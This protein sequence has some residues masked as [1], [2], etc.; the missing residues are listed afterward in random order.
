MKSGTDTSSMSDE[1]FMA[2]ELPSLSEPEQEEGESED[3]A[4]LDDDN[5][6][7]ENDADSTDDD[8][9]KDTADDE[10]DT[11]DTDSD[12]DDDSKDDSDKD[13]EDDKSDDDKDEGNPDEADK[14]DK[15][16]A[17][18]PVEV[19]DFEKQI[20]APF[21]A[22]GREIQVKDAAEAINLMQMGAN[23]QK[24]ME[25]IKPSLKVVKLLE[26]HNL[27]DED[28][29]TF[30]I[31]LDKNDPQAIRKLIKDSKLNPLD[32]TSDDE[33]EY[34][35]EPYTVDET[36][37]ALDEVL[38]RIKDTETFTQTIDV[39][40]KEWDEASQKTIGK[41]PSVIERINVQMSNGMYE[42]I[43]NNVASQKA[44]GLLV[45]LSDFDAYIQTGNALHGK[46][47]L[48][49]FIDQKEETQE[50][51]DVT[52]KIEK[53]KSDDQRNKRKRAAAPTKR[54]TPKKASDNGEKLN[55]L[56]GTDAE[57]EAL[58]AKKFGNN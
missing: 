38:D 34:K 31:D 46:G 52:P 47:E 51:K 28:K 27:L 25:V 49:Q 8:E 54:Q 55:A 39:I 35:P 15:K 10:S 48:D 56:A 20:T 17:D 9:Q 45:G 16:P 21:K 5:L 22:N 24:K 57:F 7:S 11:D 19:S 26:Q 18:K 33:T 23:Y 44:Q 36:A 53:K 29:L 43:A 37:M 2:E 58:F 13:S 50:R 12:G 4:D 42:H 14:T 41:D 6:D 40:S 1:E 3:Q 30:L 32:L